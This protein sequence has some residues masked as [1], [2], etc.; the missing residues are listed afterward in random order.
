MSVQYD[1]PNCMH[2]F[3]AAL[4]VQHIDPACVT[5]TLPMEE[6]WKLATALER[7]FGGVMT[8]DGRGAVPGRF[9]YMGFTFVAC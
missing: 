5:I 1:F 9:T 4:H 8:F 3:A 2:G 7:Q 6:W